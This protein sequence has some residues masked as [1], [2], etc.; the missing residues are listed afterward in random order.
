M[1]LVAGF[2]SQEF[3]DLKP[4]QGD[5]TVTFQH[6]GDD[7]SFYDLRVDDFPLGETDPLGDMPCSMYTS[8]VKTISQDQFNNVHL[9]GTTSLTFSMTFD[10][11]EGNTCENEKEVI[12]QLQYVEAGPTSEPTLMPVPAPVTAE[13]SPSACTPL[14]FDEDS[15]VMGLNEEDYFLFEFTGLEA[16][17]GSVAITY[18]HKGDNSNNGIYNLGVEPVTRGSSQTGEDTD[19]AEYVTS[20]TP[21][22]SET[23]FNTFYA[24]DGNLPVFME[25]QKFDENSCENEQ[26]V[27]VNVRYQVTECM[28]SAMPSAMPSSKPSPS[29]SLTPTVFTPTEFEDSSATITLQPDGSASHVFTD[30]KLAE[31]NVEVT[32]FH[33]GHESNDGAYEL[34]VAND[35]TVGESGSAACDEFTASVVTISMEAF[36]TIYLSASNSLQVSMVYDAFDMNS[37]D[38]DIAQEVAFKLKYLEAG[39]PVVMPSEE[40]SSMPVS[41]PSADPTLMPSMSP[42]SKPSLS[43]K[44]SICTAASYDEVSGEMTLDNDGVASFVFSNLEQATGSAV[45]TYYHQGDD[46]PSGYYDLFAQGFTAGTSN[47]GNAVP[48]D[49]FTATSEVV[50]K[51]EFNSYLG[52]VSGSSLTVSMDYDDDFGDNTCGNAKVV[53]FALKYQL[54]DCMVAPPEPSSA[55]VPAPTAMPSA[56]KSS[57][58]STSKSSM[59]STSKSSMPSTSKSS[60]PSTSKSSMPS[61]SSSMPSTSSSM[62]STS[63]SMPSTSSSMPSTSSSMPSTSE[64]SLMPATD[65]PSTMPTLQQTMCMPVVYD[66]SS[67]PS[68]L[69]SDVFAEFEFSDLKLAHGDVE[70]TYFHRNDNSNDNYYDLFVVGILV[71]SSDLNSAVCEAFVA[72]VT[73]LSKDDFNTVYLDGSSLSVSMRYDDVGGDNS[74]P[75]AKEVFVNLKYEEVGC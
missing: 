25:F 55:P 37:C 56:S 20:T 68:G 3:T 59:P 8:S 33:R 1:F 53:Y 62:P 18:F 21:V 63:S 34:K 52:F 48:C 75:N 16:A 6:R 64:P 30:L 31:G 71:G 70:L 22:Y 49:A 42:T 45:I 28:P 26:M 39:G 61:T 54:D 12:I 73:T 65:K 19:C 40:P 32:Y 60:M 10:D 36:N 51:D 5:V 43:S 72:T 13:P 17:I 69:T 29:L 66:E 2:A 27:Y 14:F 57:M 11:L 35:F 74:C 58:P 50:T 41:V 46:S 24:T 67:D 9:S 15:P 44:P 4:A 47:P 23:E 38:S 7:M